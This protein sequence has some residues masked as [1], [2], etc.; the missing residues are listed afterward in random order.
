MIKLM[1]AADV[2]ASGLIINVIVTIIHACL[3]ED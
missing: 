1:S 2:L 3:E